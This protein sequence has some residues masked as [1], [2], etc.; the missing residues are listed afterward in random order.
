VISVIFL[1]KVVRTL[2]AFGKKNKGAGK[3]NGRKKKFGGEKVHI[4]WLHEPYMM[5]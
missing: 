2:R 4:A 3:A 5:I 1:P